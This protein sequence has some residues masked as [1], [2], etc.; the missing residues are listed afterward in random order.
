M[1]VRAESK[2][3]IWCVTASLREMFE[4]V[5]AKSNDVPAYWIC[6]L[7]PRLMEYK[8]SNVDLERL[9]RCQCVS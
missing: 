4:V 5:N 2:K 6:T 8:L 3:V 1:T 9:A 7:V